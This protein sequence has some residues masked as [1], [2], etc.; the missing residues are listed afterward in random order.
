MRREAENRACRSQSGSRG[1]AFD[2][3][4]Q[5]V[6]DRAEVLV[7]LVDVGSRWPSG[8][9]TASRSPSS[10]RRRRA[11]ARFRSS[12]RHGRVGVPNA[13]VEI[14]TP[15]SFAARAAV[16]AP[17]GLFGSPGLFSLP[18]DSR[19]MRAGGG[20]SAGPFRHRVD[21]LNGLQRSENRLSGRGA[22]VGLQRIEGRDGASVIA[23]LGRH[24]TLAEPANAMRPRFTPGVTALA[25]CCA[26]CLAAARS[27]RRHVGGSHRLRTRR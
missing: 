26:A 3:I 17:C 6:F 18:S 21:R 9:P 27:A 15:W 5:L 10:S 13:I 19:T 1:P 14:G 20:L 7:E 2:L 22:V 8:R 16:Y 4:P 12:S 25:N 24:S 11:P 23:G